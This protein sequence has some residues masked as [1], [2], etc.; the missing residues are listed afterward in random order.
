MSITNSPMSRNIIIGLAAFVFLLQFLCCTSV[1]EERHI[2]VKSLD[3]PTG[4]EDDKGIFDTLF[5]LSDYVILEADD[6]SLIRQINK[7][8]IYKSCIYVLDKSEKHIL[9]FTRDGRFVKKYRHYGQGR[10]EYI[11]LSDFTIHDGVLYLLDRLGGCILQYTL[12]DR[13][14]SK[15]PVGRSEGICVLDSERYALNNGLGVADKK[16]SKTFFC[17]AVYDGEDLVYQSVP[18]NRHLC[19]YSYTLGDGANYFYAYDDTLFTYFPY[20]DTIYTIGKEGL[21]LPYLSVG[22]GATV[23]PEMSMRITDKLRK[24]RPVNIFSFYKWQNLMLFSYIPVEG[25]RRVSVLAD[26]DHVIFHGQFNTDKNGLPINIVAYDTD[27]PE[28]KLLSI[29]EPAV[30]HSASRRLGDEM[31]KLQEIAGQV[32]EDD[33][34]VLLFYDVN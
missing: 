14:L 4:C 11:Y 22:I 5:S 24:E 30:L 10:G 33:N 29:V 2:S 21:L 15:I 18:Y 6:A 13:F 34:P 26:W 9:S 19:G 1:R 8:V 27:E 28:R 23:T 32:V 17:Y 16:S 12:D 3:I 20:N 25:Q 7:I 31:S